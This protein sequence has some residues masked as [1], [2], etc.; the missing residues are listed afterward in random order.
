M[1]NRRDTLTFAQ[2]DTLINDAMDEWVLGLRAAKRSERTIEF[3]WDNMQRFVWWLE[4]SDYQPVVQ[5]VEASHIRL[6]LQYLEKNKHRWDSDTPQSN[7]PTSANTIHAYHRCLRAFFNF[8]ERE[9]FIKVS[10]FH[11][12]RISTPKTPQRIIPAYSPEEVKNLL[13]VCLSHDTRN[14][15]R[16]SAIIYTLF[17]TGLRGSELCSLTPDRLERG[18]LRVIGKGN[19]ER[20]AM[21]SPT[22][23]K[24]IRDYIRKERADGEYLFL[25]K[26]GEPMRRNGVYQMIERRAKQAGLEIKGLHTF[27]H[28]FATQAIISGMPVNAVQ[29][30][31]GHESPTMTLRYG[32]MVTAV[33]EVEEMHRKHSPVDRMNKRKK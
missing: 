1:K 20:Y 27:R 29:S 3:Y 12:G 15:L 6:F 18:R 25:G 24:A 13:A 28:A 30:L 23:E 7:K 4:E 16:D 31:L 11:G 2:S 5:A 33:K 8:C 21:M 19:K 9:G 32:R 10:P 17:D 22:T 14:S 26:A